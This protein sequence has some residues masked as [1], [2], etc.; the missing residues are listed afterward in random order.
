MEVVLNGD[1]DCTFKNNKN[2]KNIMN[3]I[4]F[5]P[6][7]LAAALLAGCASNHCACHSRHISKEAASQIALAS[8][9]GAAIKSAELEKEHGHLQWSF[10]LTTPQTNQVTE[11][12]VDAI[13]GKILSTQAESA[14][15][16]N[17]EAKSEK[18]SDKD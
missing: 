3:L 14:S 15:D 12:N 10:D 4:K 11:V 18:D 5:I 16:E 9:P 7:T 2:S 8:V 6:L 13:T 1:A 17:R